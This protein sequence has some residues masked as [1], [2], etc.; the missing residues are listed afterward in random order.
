MKNESLGCILE[1]GLK[2]RRK[3][4]HWKRGDVCYTDK[5]YECLLRKNLNYEIKIVFA[6]IF[7]FSPGFLS[8]AA[9]ALCQLSSKSVEVSNMWCN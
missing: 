6:L 8:L 2:G 4:G 3:S 9:A 5:T 1:S 7:F